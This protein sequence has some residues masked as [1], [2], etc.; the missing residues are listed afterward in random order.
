MEAGSLQKIT[1][2]L[3]MAGIYVNTNI[4]ALDTQIRLSQAQDSL[5]TSLRKLSSGLR[6]TGAADDASGLAISEKLRT[7]VKG[8]DRAALNSQDAISL[9]QTAEGALDTVHGI[10]QRMRELAVQAAN[11]TL[12]ATDRVEIQKEIEQLKGEIDRISRTTE[13]NTKKL[14]NGDAT[15]VWTSD[16]IGIEVIARDVA[17]D[18]GT[19]LVEVKGSGGQVQV[20]ESN[21]FRAP[22]ATAAA[23]GTTPLQNLAN[24]YDPDGNF[25]LA[26]PKKLTVWN[27]SKSVDI[28]LEATMTLNDVA[29]KIQ[30]AME[31]L[32]LAGSQVQYVTRVGTIVVAS[33][34]VGKAGEVFFSGDED[35][36]KAFGFTVRQAGVDPT[37]TV[38]VYNGSTATSGTLATASIATNTA[39]NIMQGI[40]LKFTQLNA[41]VNVA[42]TIKTDGTVTANINQAT[43]SF[44]IHLVDHS[45]TFHIGANKNQTM[46]MAI[47]R[48]DT[49][50]L[51]IDNL[52][53]VDKTAAEE[54]IKKLDSAIAI[55]S[56]ERG[57]MGAVINRLQKTID[58]LNI[59]KENMSASE[60][61]IRDLD[62][63]A[64]T[65]KFTK[66]QILS[67]TAIAML[68]QANAIPQMV[69]QLLR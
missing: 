53:V 24:F 65:T 54:A 68:A 12:T 69:L 55:V 14:L 41:G 10:L 23:T 39:R 30:S 28:Q 3:A 37:L 64:E 17:K 35:V 32:G 29:N 36:M 21:I 44:T 56:S 57:K 51:G 61:R 50:S 42:V 7:Q 40:D 38:T 27:G 25:I 45:L 58:N 4:P 2:R 20:Q 60:S 33:G 19:H 9:L 43:S 52:L 34:V 6:I 59:Q 16:R 8:L 1:R 49:V 26:T 47:G 46:N 22:G 63:A 15:V 66:S 13:F 67:Q 11:E 31:T 5:Q 62:M 48:I 18:F